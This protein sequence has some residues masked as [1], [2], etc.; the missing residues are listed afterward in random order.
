MKRSSKRLST[1]P[2]QPDF[3]SRAP[4][5]TAAMRATVDGDRAAQNRR[6]DRA[7]EAIAFARSVVDELRDEDGPITRE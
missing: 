4:Y 2:Q 3:S 6:L 5:R 7:A 1:E